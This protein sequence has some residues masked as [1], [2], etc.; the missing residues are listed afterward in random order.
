MEQEERMY[1]V[2]MEMICRHD[3][4]AE[5]CIAAVEEDGFAV[6]ERAGRGEDSGTVPEGTGN[7]SG[8]R[9]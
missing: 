3:R 4:T 1:Q 5:V 6:E 7:G 2:L 9:E 8:I